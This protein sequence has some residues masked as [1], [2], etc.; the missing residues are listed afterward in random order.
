[1]KRIFFEAAAFSLLAAISALTSAQAASPAPQENFPSKP[2]N[3]AQVYPAK[4]VRLIVPFSPGGISDIIARLTAERLE[5]E[6]NGRV[7]VEH[8]PGAA[9]NVGADSVAKSAPDGY[10]LILLNVGCVTIN[11]WIYK[12]YPFDPLND[13]VPIAPIVETSHLLFVPADFP[14]KSVSELIAYAKQ[15]PG[16]LN[17][18]SGGA[19]TPLHMSAVYFSRVAGVEMFHVPYKDVTHIATDLATG[20]IQV[21]FWVLAPMRSQVSAG[22]VKALAVARKTRL[23]AL[24]DVPTFDE[25]GIPGFKPGSWVGIMGPRGIPGALITI[26]NRHVGTMLDDPEVRKRFDDMGVGPLK[27]SPAE[28]SVRVRSDYEGW[29]DV[30]RAA[31]L[32]PE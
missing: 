27:E 15:A 12:N 3:T 4:P 20:R 32:K 8:R 26:L 31:G 23:A 1:M 7:L 2:T 14:V 10:T 22:R 25:L 18:A 21:A 28:F 30:V 11:P 17:Y 16:K 5:R 29:R 13:L 6:L 24:P 9:C 19:G